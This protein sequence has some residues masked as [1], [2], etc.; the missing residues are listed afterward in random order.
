MPIRVL[1]TRK[2][3]F[4]IGGRDSSPSQEG[5]FELRVSLSGLAPEDSLRAVLPS[6]YAGIPISQ[7]LDRL[8]PEAE[9][10]RRKFAS[11]F[12][13]RVNPDLPEIYGVF[14]DVFYEWRQG[15]CALSLRCASSLSEEPGVDVDLSDSVSQHL[16]PVSAPVS[17]DSGLPLL[18][19]KIEQEYRVIEYGARQGIWENKEELL[20]WLQSLTLLYFLDKHEAGIP[21][22]PSSETDRRLMP[23]L[24]SLQSQHLIGPWEETGTFVITEDGRR[25]IGGLLAETESYIELYD[26][27]KDTEID[28]EF[29]SVEFDTGRGI[30]L[31][32]QAFLF[33]GLD[34]IRT[35][36]LLRLYDGT[37][38]DFI[39][40]W[41]SLID[42]EEFFDG[43]LEPVVNRYDVDE[44]LMVW[45]MET[46][47]SYLEE[48]EEKARQ[49]EAQKELMRRVS[50]S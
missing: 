39:S 41:K 50:R 28:L 7:L 42:C 17:D 3:D 30:D 23:A 36:F 27:F 22:A 44:A 43:I 8:F 2:S 5:A 12:D 24:D 13:L 45:I 6:D 33:E 15:R 18:D 9:E 20:G 25:F 16:Y 32:V 48:R 47:Y 35:V 10:Q 19:L 11:M 38:D 1:I 31:R 26:H 21:L 14:L 37:L 46:G 49:L 4:K 40:T 34:P 29:G